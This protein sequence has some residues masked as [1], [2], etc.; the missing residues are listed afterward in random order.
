MEQGVNKRGVDTKQNQRYPNTIR[1]K[2]CK[3]GVNPKYTGAANPKC[4]DATG[5]EPSPC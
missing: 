5:K 3:G 2:V 4:M 1:S